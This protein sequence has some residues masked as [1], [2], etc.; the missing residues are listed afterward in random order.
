MQYYNIRICG[1]QHVL[2]TRSRVVGALAV[3]AGRPASVTHDLMRTG[4]DAPR[5]AA[6]VQSPGRGA[7]PNAPRSASGAPRR[8]A[9][10]W[11]VHTATDRTYVFKYCYK[12]RTHIRV[13][14][15]VDGSLPI[16]LKT[17]FLYNYLQL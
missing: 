12:M 17:I 1:K 2:A 4:P 5:R 11:H 10:V 8:V 3:H 7:R 13:S 14:Q 15:P 9:P 6:R 16:A